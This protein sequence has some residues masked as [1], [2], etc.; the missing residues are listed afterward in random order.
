VPPGP[1]LVVV[2]PP[3]APPRVNNAAKHAINSNR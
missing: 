2:L 1:S 3:Q